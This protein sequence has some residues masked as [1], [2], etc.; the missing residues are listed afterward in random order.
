MVE[1]PGPD[2]SDYQFVNNVYCTLNTNTSNWY[3]WNG[4]VPTPFVLNSNNIR[5]ETSVLSNNNESYLY[6]GT[7]ADNYGMSNDPRTYI[8][9]LIFTS[10]FS[11]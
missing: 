9:D 4:F 2:L 1:E 11:G 3:T 7:G 6:L 8:T 5:V 10:Q